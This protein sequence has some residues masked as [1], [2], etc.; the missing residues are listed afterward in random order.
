MRTDLPGE[1]IGDYV[2]LRRGT[3]YQGALVGS[4]GPA[5][6]GLGSIMPGGGFRENHYKTYGGECPPELMLYPGEM[7]VSLKGA[8]KDGDMI[9]SVARVPPTVKSGRLTQDTVKLEFK[10]P[11]PEIQRYV[12]WI[13][14]T[15][16]YRAYCAGRATGSAVVALSRQDF[17][18]YP[19]PPLTVGR[20]RIVALLE[21]LEEKS[22][23]KAALNETLE[24]TARTLF[25][26]WF[27]DFDPVRAK[28]GGRAPAFMNPSAAALF[29][30][31]FDNA[32]RSPVPTTW[33]WGTLGEVVDIHDSR[34]V[35]LSQ[36]ERDERRGPY[37]YY[38]AAGLVD[39]VDDFLFE[40]TFALVGEDG[41][42][43]HEDGAPF[44]QYVWGQFWVNNHA[45]VLTAKPPYTV[46]HLIY[47]LRQLDVRPYVTG[48]VQPKLSQGR[49]KEIP[50]IRAP[51]P[52]CRA[53]NAAVGPLLASH[54]ANT[55]QA[56]TLTNLRDVFL[57]K[58]L[59]GELRSSDAA[60]LVDR[61]V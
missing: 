2:S 36:R 41:S 4:P 34:R 44:V 60:Q 7:Y 25:R 11:D 14:R 32:G 61:A 12:Y 47:L 17:L 22:R 8:T 27:V 18:A 51:E 19:V 49:M 40:G 5:L 43:A 29:P 56:R 46:E 24:L 48:A 35:P 13:L 38:G 37:P 53:F 33:R 1:T 30:D 21:A 26:S 42:V 31:R 10:S 57:P 58:L 59:S 28:A 45:H 16:D 54:R 50:V 3:T 23:L 52:V 55:E 39:H 20:R 15:P 6:L 9:G